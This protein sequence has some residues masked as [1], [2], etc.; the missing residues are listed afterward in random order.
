[1]KKHTNRSFLIYLYIFLPL[2]CFSGSA[3]AA[4]CNPGMFCIMLYDP[5]CGTDGKT[6]SNSCM[7]ENACVGVAYPGICSEPPPACPDQDKD[8]FSPIGG[9][10]GPRDCNDQDP[11]INPD[12]NCLAIYDPV[13][14]ADGVTYANSCE[15]L[16]TCVEIAH[17]G[18]CAAPACRDKDQDGYSPDGGACGPVDCNDNDPSINPGV[19]CPA[20]Y[21]PVC[22]SDG[23][24]YS[25][26]CAAKQA[27]T[28]I[29]YRG[30]CK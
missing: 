10:C 21:K 22:G 8:G 5:V 2:A 18:E 12:M 13:C 7:A 20:V 19:A 15:A 28:E 23:T 3:L 6:Y 1:M 27:C 17:P 11:N 4:G 26:V 16:R 9:D 29:A 25:N 30:V 14:G 24:T